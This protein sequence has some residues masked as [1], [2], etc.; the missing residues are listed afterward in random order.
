MT[1][2]VVRLLALTTVLAQTLE[3][4]VVRGVAHDADTDRLI[5]SGVVT[6]LDAHGAGIRAV[7]TDSLGR[8]AILAPAA[9]TYRLRFERLGYKPVTTDRFSLKAGETA[10]RTLEP[11]AVT[12][13]LQEIVVTDRPRCRVVSEADTVTVRVWTAVRSVL[14]SAA[15]AEAG[16]FPHVTIERYERDYDF[17]NR[18][19]NESRWTTSGASKSPFV[20]MAASE[21]EKHGFVKRVGDSV[22]FYAPDARTLIA[23]EFLRTHCFRVRDER[24]EQ[25]RV[26]LEIEPLPNRSLPDIKGTLWV[27][28]MSGELRR[29][30][31]VYVNLPRTVPREGSEGWVEFLRTPRGAWLVDKWAMRLPLVG[32]RRGPQPYG[33]A[34]PVTGDIAQRETGL[35]GVQEEGG[36]IVSLEAEGATRRSAPV[37]RIALRGVVRSQ[38]GDPVPGARAFLSGTSHSSVTDREGSFTML[39]VTPGSYRLSFTHPRFDT[40]GIVGPVIDVDTRSASDLVLMMLADEEIATAACAGVESP[41]NHGPSLLY[42]FVRDGP[43]PAVL[44]GATVSVEWRNLRKQVTGVAVA[45]QSLATESDADGRYLFC[46]VPTDVKLTIRVDGQSR[47]SADIPLGPLHEAVSRFDLALPRS[48]SGGR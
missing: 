5:E 43:G 9:G 39:D 15:A 24:R 30:E 47:H 48:R 7:L 28:A 22:E 32:E 29:L 23:E 21:L 19:V 34:S 25:G 42:G 13:S 3:G 18:L 38:G 8:F 37:R 10:S 45:E 17:M 11:A 4:Q 44:S 35:L 14:A 2:S 1:R 36:R 12:L 40:L 31:F 16:L 6:L 46:G 41:A 26:G 33:A 20:A 27:D